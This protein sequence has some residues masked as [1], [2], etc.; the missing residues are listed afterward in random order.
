[1]EGQVSSE[2]FWRE[3]REAQDATLERSDTVSRLRER[4]PSRPP[5]DLDPRRRLPQG[6]VGGLAAAI[7][8]AATVVLSLWALRGKARAISFEIG[9]DKREGQIGAS[10]AAPADNNLP[11]VFSDGSTVDL[12][13]GARARVTSLEPHGA[14]LTLERGRALASVIHRDATR[15]EVAAGPFLVTVVGTQFAV[16]W[17]PNAEVFRLDLHE[18]EV[19]VSG[20]ILPASQLVKAGETLRVSCHDGR[21]ELLD[22]HEA[23]RGEPP[24]TAPSEPPAIAWIDGGTNAVP[25]ALDAREASRSQSTEASARRGGWLELARA[26]RYR[27]ALDAA[28][29]RGFELE[30]R[31]AA[32]RDLL[33]LGDAA[34]LAGNSVRGRQAYL[35]ARD[36]IAGGGR[37]TY[38]LGLLAFD[39]QRDFAEA[40]RWFSAYLD[41][42]SDGELRS[43]AEGRLFEALERAG[44]TGRARRAAEQY[45]VEYPTGAYA[46]SARQLTSR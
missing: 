30:C 44:E 22:S 42:N 13:S 27:E 17:D 9:D 43:E 37:A 16:S 33:L 20:S 35:A 14:H 24:S 32:G 7:A 34:R 29:R 18:G 11:I 25:G 26:G 10:L 39:Q 19:R 38:G 41:H 31:R 12:E 40:A 4:M 6:W 3:V 21:S 28:E 8:L 1:M 5:P 45:L 2:K 15:W 36:K 23:N 46:A